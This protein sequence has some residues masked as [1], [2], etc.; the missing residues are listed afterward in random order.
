MGIASG[1]HKAAQAMK[2]AATFQ[3]AVDAVRDINHKLVA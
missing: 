2:N 1:S 3:S